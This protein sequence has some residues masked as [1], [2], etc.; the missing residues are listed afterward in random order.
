[1]RVQVEYVAQVRTSAGLSEEAI[2]L[3]SGAT[4]AELVETVCRGRDSL[5]SVLCDAAGKLHSSV[6]VF[7]GD[8]QAASD[9]VLRDGN[10]VT[11][12]SPISGG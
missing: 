10:T 12:L 6:L 11:F 9:T 3:A 2:E 7:V 8:V 4:V 5:V 1:M